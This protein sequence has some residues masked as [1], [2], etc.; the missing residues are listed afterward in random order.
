M[1]PLSLATTVTVAVPLALGAVVY[2]NV[3]VG[4]IAGAPPT[5]N[6]LRLLTLAR[7]LTV[8]PASFGGPTDSSSR[9]VVSVGL[10]KLVQVA[11]LSVENCQ[12]PLVLL[13]LVTAMP[14]GAMAGAYAGS[15]PSE[16]DV[17]PRKVGRSVPVL[18][19]SSSLIAG[20]T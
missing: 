12:T 2:V 18:V 5:A 15:L 20:M 1:P 3:P 11:P 14:R 4:E 9:A 17:V 16:I 7:K 6:R 13:T 19:L 10:P 8:W